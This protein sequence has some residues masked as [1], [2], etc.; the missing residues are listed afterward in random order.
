MK[1]IKYLLFILIPLILIYVLLCAIGPKNAEITR[2]IDID[3][4]PAYA[5]NLINNIDNWGKWSSWVVNDSTLVQTMNDQ[6]IGVGAGYSWESE[7]NGNGSL[8]IIESD[9]NQRIK[10]KM[11][12]DGFDGNSYGE[13]IINTEG[14]GSNLSWSMSADKDFPFLIRGY[15]LVSGFKS[16]LKSNFDESLVMLKKEAE[17][18]AK[19]NYNG[20]KIKGIKMPEKHFVISRAEV[21]IANYQQFYTQNLGAL[22]GKVTPTGIEMDGMPSGLFFK[23]DEAKGTADMAAALPV[24]EN[25]AVA[26]TTSYTIPAKNAISLDFYGDYKD[27]PV[28]HEA[29][30]EFINDR[31]FL[32]DIPIIEEYL[33]DPTTEPDPSK[34]LTR[35]IYYLA[36]QE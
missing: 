10:S 28:A 17:N 25:I 1:A 11:N 2:Q 5:Y 9:N 15:M 4:P 33:S 3:A 29:I 22:F 16:K 8:E 20:Y 24:V 14:K 31:G 19:G 18:R 34:W 12:F 32:T 26:G 23:W 30:E 36:D 35:I 6:R 7:Q 27:T 21:P 13:Y